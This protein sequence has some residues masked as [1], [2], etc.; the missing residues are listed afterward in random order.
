M[1]MISRF[2][3]IA[4]VK[5]EPWIYHD[6]CCLFYGKNCKCIG[7]IIIY[8]RAY[9]IDFGQQDNLWLTYIEKV[10]KLMSADIDLFASNDVVFK[11]SNF[12]YIVCNF[13]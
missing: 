11:S 6:V 10:K 8:I 13:A 1:S 3:N 9:V 5:R 7:L 2:Y 4:P 12:P